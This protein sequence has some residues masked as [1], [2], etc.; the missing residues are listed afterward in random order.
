[1]PDKNNKEKISFFSKVTS[2][3]A[4][5][6]GEYKRTR[7]GNNKTKDVTIVITPSFL[8]LVTYLFLLV[9]KFIDITL[10]NRDNEY[11]SVII[12]QMM[13]F[14]L[15]G[16]LWCMLKGE[17]YIKKLRISAPKL[18]SLLLIVS[19]AVVMM[20]GGVL[21]GMMFEGLDS[22]SNN[23]SLYDTFISKRDG[24]VSNTLYLVL[25]YVALPALCEEFVYRGILCHEYEDKGVF[26]AIILSSLF[27]G[28]LH[29]NVQNLLVYFFC[30]CILALVLYATRSLWGAV[31]AHFI[32]NLFGVFGQPYM[33][34]LYRLTKDS[35]LLPMIVGTVFFLSAAVFC[36]QA[37]KLYR[38]YL[39]QG[40]SSNYRER[41]AMG[42]AYFS[43][44]FFSVIKDP[45]TLVC[46]VIYIIAV[47]ISW[48]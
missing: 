8:V 13:I 20:S 22:L 27:F 31:I 42:S 10:L 45:F 41:I 1:M 16:S 5:K 30:G 24:S 25:A 26:R 28:L 39:R 18:D 11:M 44:A 46:A 15:P 14:L 48:L 19:A 7:S 43:D 35:R 40:F 33:A 34:T 37:S 2:S 12:L 38:K 36:G 21:I 47:I 4:T 9:S 3:V 32:Y 17:K 6:Y 23:F 29:F